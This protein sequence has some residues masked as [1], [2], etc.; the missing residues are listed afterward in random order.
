MIERVEGR[1]LGQQIPSRRRTAVR[2]KA[3]PGRETAGRHPQAVK[4]KAAP[5]W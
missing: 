1:L 2:S 3:S 4:A 5:V